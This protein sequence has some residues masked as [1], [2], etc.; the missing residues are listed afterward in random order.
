MN[1]S[2]VSVMQLFVYAMVFHAA[3][4][5]V[6]FDDKDRL[7]FLSA[8]DLIQSPEE[9]EQLRTFCIRDA[10][11]AQLRSLVVATSDQVAILAAWEIVERFNNPLQVSG[12]EV[13]DVG[14]V[15]WF[16]EYLEDRLEITLPREWGDG[17][18][19]S[20]IFGQESRVQFSGQ[21]TNDMPYIL[22]EG[23]LVTPQYEILRDA[24]TGV[25]L[26]RDNHVV[27][28]AIAG[29]HVPADNAITVFSTDNLCFVLPSVVSTDSRETLSCFSRMDSTEPSLLWSSELWQKQTMS[30]V[31][32]AKQWEMICLA[33]DRIVVFS[34]RFDFAA[35]HVF[36]VSTGRAIV[37]F[38][39]SQFR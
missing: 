11:D 6:G 30:G 33:E 17:H 8:P 13:D 27:A 3:S 38:T 4:L 25:A 31:F 15:G 21:N 34:A 12:S 9:F 29:W 7:G 18:I 37:R 5:A 32:P 2:R 36:D 1:S 20:A 23:V 26:R 28:D 14:S 22:D 10:E 16:V 39:T 24:N 35:V 19:Q